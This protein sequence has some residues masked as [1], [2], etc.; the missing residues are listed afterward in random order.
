MSNEPKPQ[1]SITQDQIS[2]DQNV[3]D[4]PKK[5]ESTPEVKRDNIISFLK[6]YTKWIILLFILSAF[7]SVGNLL[8]PRITGS[9]LDVYKQNNLPQGQVYLLQIGL[10]AVGVLIFT[11]LQSIVTTYLSARVVANMRLKMAKKLSVQTNQFIAKQTTGKILTNFNSDVQT[12]SDLVS[13][14]VVTFFSASLLLIGSIV[15]LL[16]INWYLALWVLSIIPL[17]VLLFVFVFGSIGKLFRASQANLDKIN[18][19]INES[20]VAA[21]LVR[22]LNSQRSEINKF[23]QASLVSKELNLKIVYAFSTLIPVVNFLSNMAILSIVW[24][25]GDLV[26]KSQLSLGDLSAF[27]SYIG[28]LI[29][30]IFLLSFVSTTASRAVVS[31]KRINEIT[32][33]VPEFVEGNHKG[34]L[35]GKIEFKDI[36]LNI[37]NRSV[38]RNINLDFKAGQ[39][40]AILG[41]TGSGKTQ[42]MYLLT[43]LQ[44]SSSGKILIDDI[45]ILDWSPASLYS[46]MGLVF[47][48]SLIFTTSLQENISLKNDIEKS[49][50]DRIINTS[51][52]HDLIMS[53]P[54]GLDTEI[55]ERGT[56]LS[57]GQKQRLMLARALAI[58]PSILLL[59]DFTARVDLATEQ[60]IQAALK[61]N[62]PK[63]TLVNITQKIEPVKDYDQIVLIMEGE[64]IATGKH[65]ELLESCLEYKQIWESQQS[66]D[67]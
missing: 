1:I 11:V 30:P 20:I 52:L 42:L 2:K 55:S 46:Q 41:P 5:K 16:S 4:Q 43:A 29:T 15:S 39:R 45:D 28:L 21:G 8:V 54:Q 63:L 32:E 58:N 67:E 40:I 49:E 38:L 23:N 3:K 62:Y 60:S 22:V 26:I 13:Q 66:T 10:I 65:T 7:S 57:G 6:P 18:R 12:I 48:D 14:G 51:Q 36:S 37:Q 59:D 24:I 53:L 50:M 33:S 27:I 34:K 44:K 31:L 35:E 61:D 64:I 9:A 25:G 17:I 56:N 19:I 47:Q